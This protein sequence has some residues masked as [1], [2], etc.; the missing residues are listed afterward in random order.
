MIHM[1]QGDI[2]QAD[3][4]A[5]V[6]TVNCVGVMGRGVAL[7]FRKA[8]PENFKLYKSVCDKQELTPGQVLTYSRDT[9]EHPRYIIN[10]PTKRHWKGHSRIE[11]I[12]TGLEALIAEVQ[13]L[14]IRSIA[15]PPL[16][17]GL[18]GLDWNDVRPRIEAAFRQLLD[19]KV[20]LYE[21]AG[22]PTPGAMVKEKKI[23]R[24]SLGRAILL[25]LIRQYL[26]A[27]MDTSV[28]LL[29]IHKLMYFMEEAGEPLD[30]RYKKAAYGPYSERMR[31]VLS[32]IEGHFLAGYGDGQDAP[33]KAI[34]VLPGADLKAM[35]F[36]QEQ[37]ETLERLDRVA[38]LIRGFETPFGMELLSTVYWVAKSEQAPNID[39]IIAGVYGWN[40][41]KAI[42][43]ERQIRLAYEVLQKR[44][45]LTA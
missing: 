20:L 29:E 44:G 17:C 12:E 40:P 16:G 18:G 39:A 45:W 28:T 32:A 4:E 3:A 1:A 7:Q 13:R 27:L 34:E 24:M 11:Y 15:I 9:L 10:F 5:L 43:Q 31:H 35:E 30:L 2:L 37:P 14:N 38:E 42:F 26:S 23:P 8:Y 19:V 25:A 36:L 41:H 22:A 21:P 6:N 33:Q